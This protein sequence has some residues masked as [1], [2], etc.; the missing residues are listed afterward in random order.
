[1]NSNSF[2]FCTVTLATD[3]EIV[4]ENLNQI[5]NIYKNT[6]LFIIKN[7]FQRDFRRLK[8]LINNP[9]NGATLSSK[10]P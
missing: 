5:N 8:Y 2:N 10:K 9:T 6:K 4:N 3:A 7:I 1:M